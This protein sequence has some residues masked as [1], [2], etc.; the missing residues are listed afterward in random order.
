MLATVNDAIQKTNYI[1]YKSWL[2]IIAEVC[3]L[4]LSY[5]H[6]NRSRKSILFLVHSIVYWLVND[7]L[8]VWM[9]KQDRK[10][11]WMR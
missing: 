7:G 9:I 2:N 11:T 10:S 1:A 4:K 5:I 8:M 6:A 3:W